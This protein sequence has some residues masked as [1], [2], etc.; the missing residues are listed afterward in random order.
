M[1]L[2][3][4]TGGDPMSRDF[5]D[6]AATGL[7]PWTPVAGHVELSRTHTAEAEV[8]GGT[9]VVEDPLAEELM[10]EAE[11]AAENYGV[12]L[13]V[14]S[15]GELLTPLQRAALA[16]RVELTSPVTL[17]EADEAAREAVERRQWAEAADKRGELF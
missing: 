8:E 16:K 11:Q 7:T 12:D 9:R 10:A 15:Y 17:A 14:K 1:L 13:A 2:A 4:G 5:V 6:V 3:T